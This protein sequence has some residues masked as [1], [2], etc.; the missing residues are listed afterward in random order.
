MPP[1]AF[2][3]HYSDSVFALVFGEAVGALSYEVF[4]GWPWMGVACAN[5]DDDS[6]SL[7]LWQSQV[8]LLRGSTGWI[9]VVFALLYFNRCLDLLF[10]S[11][12]L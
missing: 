7:E 4:E 11:F 12:S 2:W 9:L 1:D 5:N 8:F 10:P 6:S 3:F